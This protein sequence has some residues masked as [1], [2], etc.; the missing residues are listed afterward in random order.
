MKIEFYVII[1]Y[2][3]PIKFIRD[4]LVGDVIVKDFR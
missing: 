2:K 4:I 3:I 1:E